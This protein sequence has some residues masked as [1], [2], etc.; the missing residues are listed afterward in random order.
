[1]AE[2]CLEVLKGSIDKDNVV[3]V[4]ML[5]EMIEDEGLRDAALM[6]FF[7]HPKATYFCAKL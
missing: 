5:A 3:E 4:W 2:D 6:Y 1:M 7:D